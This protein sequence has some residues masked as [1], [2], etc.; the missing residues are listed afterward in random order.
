VRRLPGRRPGVWHAIF[1]IH[2]TRDWVALDRLAGFDSRSIVTHAML[3]RAYSLVDSEDF[4]VD[5][6]REG[7]APDALH[8]AVLCRLLLRADVF[9]HFFDTR[10][11]AQTRPRATARALRL[12]RLA[13][14][15]LV[16]I[17]SGLDVVHWNLRRTRFDFLG[18]LQADYPDWDL[19]G[20]AADMKELVDSICRIAD[21][22]VSG[23]SGCSRVMIREDLR[24]KYFPIDTRALVP[25]EPQAETSRPP[26]IVHA[27]NHRHIK[28]TGSLIAAVD[29]L[30][31][32]G[33]DSELRLVERVARKEA[34][35]IYASADIV[36][37]QFC[38]G[39][40]GVFALEGL[41]L[42]K[43]V[44]AYLDEEHLG[45]PV[46][47]LPIVNAHSGNLERVLAVLLRV[48]ELRNRLGRAGRAAVEQFQSPEAIAEVWERIYRHV[49]QREPL[50]L[51]DTRHFSRERQPRAFTEDPSR[52]EF[53]PVPVTDLMAEIR[54]AL[55]Q[56]ACAA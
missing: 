53:W 45:D 13:G 44:V 6:S 22:V 11:A 19:R 14:V 2:I 51:G 12:L 50:E 39:S 46:F 30:R 40:Y 32:A 35:A 47:N 4:D 17:P 38:I 31:L 29:A 56:H 18:R 3:N 1:P 41:A 48:P 20:E 33:I 8:W 7:V 21:F 25:P 10:F 27:P 36:A 5:L 54:A 24:F 52:P 49:W 28:G 9:V 55:E 42:G 23:D 26:R 15:R 34:Q 16:A 37:D 43:T